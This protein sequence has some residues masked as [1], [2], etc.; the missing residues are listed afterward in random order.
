MSKNRFMTSE[1]IDTYSNLK[2]LNLKKKN[3]N[4]NFIGLPILHYT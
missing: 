2:S 1:N 3:D 4:L